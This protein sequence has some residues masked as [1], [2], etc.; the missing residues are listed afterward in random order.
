MSMLR[1][2]Q[3]GHWLVVRFGAPRLTDPA[4][5][6][7]LN[8]SLEKKLDTLPLRAQVA[9]DFRNVEFVSSQI[10]G[11]MLSAKDRMGRKHGTLVLTRLGTH[12]M[13]VLRITKLDRQFTIRT[14]LSETIGQKSA[15][16][17]VP[18]D[19]RWMD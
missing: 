15:A 17:N 12:V 4:T 11:M 3:I 18:S 8:A 9:I 14:S 1:Y 2:E 5:I 19:V 7:M 6:S 16:R 10:I 13:D